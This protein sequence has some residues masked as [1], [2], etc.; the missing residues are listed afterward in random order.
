MYTLQG[1]TWPTRHVCFPCQ[2]TYTQRVLP[3]G[4]PRTWQTF[5]LSST[6]LNRSTAPE[7]KGTQHSPQHAGWPIRG[8]IPNF[9][10]TT[11]NKAVGKS[12]ASVDNQLLGLPSPYHRH[13][14][15]TFNTCSWGPIH[16]SLTDSGGGYCLE[17][18]DLPHTTLR[19]S[20]PRS[21]FST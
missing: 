9:S 16:R 11:A 12:Q 2:T 18:A 20:Q 1:K 21:S 13:A 4:G 8:S 14:I 7:K 17:G 3:V 5:V 6:D 19:P 15:G 10:P